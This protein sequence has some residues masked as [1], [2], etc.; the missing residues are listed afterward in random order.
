MKKEKKRKT[1]TSQL[2]VSTPLWLQRR[3][4]KNIVSAASSRV[5]PARAQRA[6][7]IMVALCVDSKP[8]AEPVGKIPAKIK[9]DNLAPGI[10]YSWILRIKR[11]VSTIFLKVRLNLIK[12]KAFFAL[13]ISKVTSKSILFDSIGRPSVN[14]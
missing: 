11:F 6:L 2:V 1:K 14:Q 4:L 8:L 13:S 12:A 5:S 9:R 3:M 10:V 7:E